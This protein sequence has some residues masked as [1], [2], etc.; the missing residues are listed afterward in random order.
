MYSRYRKKGSFPQVC[1][2]H[3]RFSITVLRVLALHVVG[4][5]SGL[6]GTK[7]ALLRGSRRFTAALRRHNKKPQLPLHGL[8][9]YGV[10]VSDRWHVLK[11]RAELDDCYID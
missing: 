11:A 3:R 5:F 2:A 4:C 1:V 9:G 6:P 10:A 7:D 8:T